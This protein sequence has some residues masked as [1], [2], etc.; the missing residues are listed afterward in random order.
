[1]VQPAP[2]FPDR[3][4]QRHL[5]RGIVAVPLVTVAILIRPRIVFV[6][7]RVL[8]GAARGG[9]DESAAVVAPARRAV[10]DRV[11]PGPGRS[12]AVLH[13]QSAS[14]PR[15]GLEAR[16]VP[17]PIIERRMCRPSLLQSPREGVRRGR[18]VPRPGRYARTRYPTARH[19]A[20]KSYGP[21]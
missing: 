19:L 18:P 6:L 8:D 15:R 5:V 4:V 20:R 11:P 1:M 10:V 17:F 21:L 14:D 16:S 2:P 9:A 3:H 7:L 12:S 13:R